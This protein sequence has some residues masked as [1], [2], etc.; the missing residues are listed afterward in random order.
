M[1]AFNSLQDLNELY[2]ENGLDN[3]ITKLDETKVIKIPTTRFGAVDG[4]DYNIQ[5]EDFAEWFENKY[6]RDTFRNF[7]NEFDGCGYVKPCYY[8]GEKFIYGY[9]FIS[10]YAIDFELDYEHN[11]LL[12]PYDYVIDFF[13]DLKDKKLKLSLLSDWSEK[14]SMQKYNRLKDRADF[15]LK[16]KII[17]FENKK[18]KAK[19]L[20]HFCYFNK[21]KKVDSK[22]LDW[23]GIHQNSILP[24]SK[25]VSKLEFD[26]KQIDDCIDFIFNH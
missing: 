14:C 25:R 8:K 16:N 4:F 3:V 11:M 9:D 5:T 6:N 10:D 22:I 12:I 23:F 2:K 26:K 17:P 20:N 7:Y 15:R 13:S 19:L 1:S 21:N 24:M 18:D